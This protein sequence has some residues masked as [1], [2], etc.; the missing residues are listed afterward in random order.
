MFV[1]PD[2]H[3][4]EHVRV[5]HSAIPE[6]HRTLLLQRM[7]TQPYHLPMQGLLTS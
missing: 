5:K 3:A 4:D 6:M 1:F 2:P 7:T